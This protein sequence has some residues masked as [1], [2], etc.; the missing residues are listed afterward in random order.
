M[1][2][3]IQLPTK[4][5]FK[6]YKELSLIPNR[7]FF[8]NWIHERNDEFVKSLTSTSESNPDKKKSYNPHQ[9][10]C[11]LILLAKLFTGVYYSIMG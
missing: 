5:D 10:Y 3:S 7:K 1:A 11:Q 8:Q 9:N 4:L 2:I 6:R